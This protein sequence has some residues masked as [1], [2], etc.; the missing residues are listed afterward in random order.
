MW[1]LTLTA[2]DPSDR[3]KT[4]QHTI[5]VPGDD[6]AALLDNA[7]Y[8]W[9]ILCKMMDT[10]TLRAIHID[11]R[12]PRRFTA[13]RIKKIDG[14]YFQMHGDRITSPGFTERHDAW[15]YRAKQGEQAQ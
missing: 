9:S 14:Q 13:R 10:G 11:Y 5:S 1:K 2:V 8:R 12:P 15:F 7:E 3:T 6:A 4:V